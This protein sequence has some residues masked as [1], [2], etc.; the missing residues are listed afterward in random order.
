SVDRFHFTL[1]A[2]RVVGDES[3]TLQFKAV[4]ANAVKIVDVP[5][6]IREDVPEPVFTLKAPA[7][8]DGRETIEVVPQISNAK[9]MQAQ[10]AGN[11]NTTW[12]V[13]DI[14]VI[15]EIEPGK[16]I[17]KRAQN[18]GKMTVT[19]AV[20]NGGK[21]TT[22]AIQIVVKE[23]KKDA[24]VHRIPGKDEKP[25]DNQF[26]AR[27]DNNEGTLH[28]NGSLSDTA[29]SVFL[30]V[31]AD[32]KLVKNES[33]KLT[34]S[35]TYAFS[36]KLNS[37]LIKYKVEFGSKSG[38]SETVLNTVTNLVC[39]DAYIIDGQSNA[40]ATDWGKDEHEYTSD[41]I[42]SFG[43]MGGDVS[44]GWGGAVRRK[45]GAWEIGYWGMDLA[46]HLME[47]RKIPICII[48]GA[49][50]GTLIEMHQRNPTDHTDQKTIYGRLLRRVELAGLTH[51]IRGVLWH[52]GENDQQAQGA[53]GGYGWET[54]RQYFVD[55]SA[56]WKQDYP[57]TQRY[58]VFQIWPNSCSMGGNRASDM[59]RDVQRT[60]PRLYS[61]MSVMSTLG[62][63][64]VGTCHYPAA[65]YAAMARL[66]SPL[67]E[68][69]N[70]GKVFDKSIAPPDLK[71]AYYTTDK[72]DEIALE[73]DQPM[74]WS[75]ALSGQFYLDGKGG[76]IESGALS[77]NVL[78]LKLASATAAKTITYLV[79]KKWDAKNLLYGKN[80]IAAL[81]FCEVPID[82]S[83][84]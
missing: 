31:Y 46:K 82:A 42:R 47:S 20:N 29:D 37:G 55:M 9:E 58:Y 7:R 56:A 2:G 13:S 62:I 64:P 81:T 63:K 71:K 6:T 3:L 24:W 60:L 39:G 43:S 14:A 50:G 21:P 10:G 68:R 73:F 80:R 12:T 66:I 8:W 65:G 22:Q 51:G 4:C 34:A 72:M 18:S 69:D 26:Y 78:K 61:N 75:D 54:Y 16:L 48:N 74:A 83:A 44:K 45:G 17:L 35:K 5:V 76:K 23:P 41:W 28:Y 70:Y 33:Q 25:V 59:L 53:S 40:V 15:K 52:Q 49:V 1:D 32:D 38:S 67:V 30:K 84:P 11:L 57:N 79:D 27:D 36:V 77:G 19:A